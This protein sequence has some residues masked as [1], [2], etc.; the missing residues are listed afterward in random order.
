[1]SVTQEEQEQGNTFLLKDGIKYIFI[2]VLGSLAQGI[3]IQTLNIQT[4]EPNSRNIFY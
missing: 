3:A 1:M 2:F 4:T